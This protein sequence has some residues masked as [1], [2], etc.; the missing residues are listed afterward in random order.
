[1]SN[2]N[3]YYDKYLKYKNKYLNLQNQIGGVHDIPITPKREHSKVITCQGDEPTCWAH[4]TTRLIIKI[5]KNI[6][7]KYFSKYNEECNYYFNTTKCSNDKFNIFD[8]F[9]QIKFGTYTCNSNDGIEEEID[10][11]DENLSALLFHFI[12]KTLIDQ[13]GR[14]K[15]VVV[16]ISCFYILDYLTYI[17]ITEDLIKTTLAYKNKAYTNEEQSYFKLLITKL[18]EIF[19]DVKDNLSTKRLNPICYNMEYYPLQ[20]NN[21]VYSIDEHIYHT[22][23]LRYDGDECENIIPVEISFLDKIKAKIPFSRNNLE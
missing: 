8:C 23:S 2:N 5:I 19:K 16:Y 1:M 11:L 7:T 13:Y 10:W 20:P 17:D 9:L 15:A 4:S 14:K 6:F 12:F 3:L 21:S 22:P 18:V